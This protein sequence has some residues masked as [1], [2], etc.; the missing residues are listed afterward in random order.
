MKL[1][2]TYLLQLAFSHLPIAFEII[3]YQGMQAYII[4]KQLLNI[5]WF[6]Y[7]HSPTE[8]HLNCFQFWTSC[9]TLEEFLNL[10]EP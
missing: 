7:H 2:P 4:L 5:P 3:P 1:F 9:V 8:G 10:S 6:G